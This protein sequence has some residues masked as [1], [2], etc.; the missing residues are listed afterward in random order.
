M[1]TMP[2]SVPTY[3]I[4]VH[5]TNF[6]QYVQNMFA[7]VPSVGTSGGLFTT[8]MSSVFTGVS[9]FFESF[10]LGVRLTS[11]QSTDMWTLVNVYGPCMDLNRTLFTYWLFDLDIPRGEDWLIIGDFNFIRAV[12]NRNKGGGRQ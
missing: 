10:V 4:S 9:V 7:F 5:N 11:T 8:W 2:A 6:S 1:F 3:Q 12:D